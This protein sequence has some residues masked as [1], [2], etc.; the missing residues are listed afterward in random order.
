MNAGAF[1]G[2]PRDLRTN[3]TGI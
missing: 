1:N 2:P 3:M